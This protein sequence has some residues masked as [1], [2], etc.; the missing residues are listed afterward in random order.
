MG[1]RQQRANREL[2]RHP[3]RAR[4]VGGSHSNLLCRCGR[5]ANADPDG[6]TNSSNDANVD[7]NTH[8]NLHTHLHADPL[9]KPDSHCLADAITLERPC[10]AAR[11]G[12]H[13]REQGIRSDTRIVRE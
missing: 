13:G 5:A 4:G 12:D 6:N 10:N 2:R 1:D 8:A 3:E 7:P 9:A 11:D